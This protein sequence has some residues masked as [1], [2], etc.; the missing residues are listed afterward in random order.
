MATRTAQPKNLVSISRWRINTV[1]VVAVLSIVVVILRLGDLQIVRSQDLAT[2]AR[3][4]I[5]QQ[6]T[7]LPS[8]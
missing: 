2:Q 6:L 5:K 3:A 7:I 1:L 8:R 4:E